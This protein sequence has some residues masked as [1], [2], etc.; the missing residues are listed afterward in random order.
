M[1]NLTAREKGFMYVITLLIIVVLGYFFGVRT[2]NNKYEEYKQQLAA[3]EQRKAY[4]DQIRAN[5]ALMDAE[6][7]LLKEECEKLE[8]SFIDKIETETI[9]QYVLD[10]FEKA[11]CPYLT[12]VSAT[13]AGMPAVTYA[14]GT[15]SPDGLVCLQVIV[16][17]VTTDG[18]TPT[19]YNRKPDLTVGAETPASQTALDMKNQF[20]KKAEDGSYDFTQRK[21]YDEFLK[22]VK[23][24]NAENPDCIKVNSITATDADGYMILTAQINFYGTSLRNRLSV[25][26]SKAPYTYW[27]GN[28]TID[29][30]GGFIGFPYVCDNEDSLW[31]GVEN[32]NANA[33]SDKPFASYYANYLFKQNELAKARGERD[34]FHMWSGSRNLKKPQMKLHRRY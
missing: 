18:Y 14:D 21:G 8:L 15:A 7:K 9:E 16:T 11:G 3:L 13:D 30:K 6:I 25:D 23:A 19:Q 32:L 20:G 17:Y 34:G 22:A 29:T 10:T 2:L 12:D 27:S 26:D 28:T 24:I 4:L 5:N 31:Y 1:N 33:V